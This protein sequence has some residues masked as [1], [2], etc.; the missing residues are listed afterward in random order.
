MNSQYHD[1][2]QPVIFKRG[3]TVVAPVLLTRAVDRLQRWRMRRGLADA[4][5]M[6]IDGCSGGEGGPQDPPQPAP[7]SASGLDARPSNTTCIAPE[8]ATGSAIIGTQR[9]FPILTFRN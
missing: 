1:R 9:A 7:A 3:T 4:I 6:L 8:R 2:V 5:V